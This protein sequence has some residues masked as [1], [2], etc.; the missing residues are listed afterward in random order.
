M[1]CLDV[2]DTDFRKLWSKYMQAVVNG[3]DIFWHMK[4]LVLNVLLSFF[5]KVTIKH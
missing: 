1:T 2:I 5:L 3:F 4:R